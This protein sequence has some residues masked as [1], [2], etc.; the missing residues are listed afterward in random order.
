[1]RRHPVIFGLTILALAGVL[2]FL[3]IYV[4]TALTEE[5]SP[6]AMQEKVGV[7]P[8]EGVLRSSEKVIEDLDAF[9]E[10][11]D[12]R[13]VVLRIDSPGGAI[14]PAQEIFDKIL[15]VKK[16]K[17][18]VASMGSVAASGGYYV[19]CAAD[20]IVANPGTITGSI[21]VIVQF[22]QVDE[23][24]GKIGLKS[25]VIKRGE[26]KDIGSPTRDMTPEEE[27]IIQGLVDD[28]YDQFIDMVTANRTISEETL[29]TISDSRIL[30]GRQAVELGLVDELGTLRN[31]VDLASVLAGIEGEPE[32]VYPEKERTGLLEYLLDEVVSSILR[33]VEG[34]GTGIEYLYP[35][36]A[37]GTLYR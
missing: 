36:G 18:V 26:H 8:I 34:R 19:A 31:A 35:G 9:K 7:I 12:I 30:S 2:C 28:I 4:I 25:R 21:G 24:L 14:V 29:R 32:V 1:M 17:V 20:R 27:K 10:D 13:A 16:K 5:K 11:D 37:G 33:A 22:S 15:D 23:L 6:F 3:A